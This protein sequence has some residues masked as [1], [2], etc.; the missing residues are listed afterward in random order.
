MAHKSMEIRK[1]ILRI[2]EQ[3]GAEAIVLGRDGTSHQT[4]T[5]LYRERS[6]K[7]HFPATG[8]MRGCTFINTLANLKRKIREADPVAAC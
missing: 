8:K 7:F 5:F 3:A 4:A 2:L 1:G 6:M